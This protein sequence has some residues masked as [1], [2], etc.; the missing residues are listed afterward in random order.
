MPL[1]TALTMGAASASPG[2]AVDTILL[3]GVPFVVDFRE[4]N[5]NGLNFWPVSMWIT[6]HNAN[7]V[8]PVLPGLGMTLRPTPWGD[9]AH[10]YSFPSNVGLV[11]AFYG[12]GPI[13]VVFSAFPM[14]P[15][16]W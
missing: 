4:L 13:G 16:R 8:T 6:P 15:S 12:D 2:L 11:V 3:P 9:D 10:Y 5:N 7:P 14:Q 1:N